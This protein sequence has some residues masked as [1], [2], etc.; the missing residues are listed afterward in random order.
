[1]RL[2]LFGGVELSLKTG[3]PVASILRQRKRVAL[4]IHLTVSCPPLFHQREQ[5]LQLLWPGLE[6]D[7]ARH[8]LR[9]M[10]YILRKT[11][12]KRLLLTGGD[13]GVGLAR[14]RV[15]C[16]VLEFEAAYQQ[17][18]F[19][20]AA[21]LYRGE[22]AKGFS[23]PGVAPAFGTWL[24][25]ERMRLQRLAGDSAWRVAED[26]VRR[27][28]GLHARQWLRKAREFAPFDEPLLRR[29]VA[30]LDRFGD[31]SGAVRAYDQFESLLRDRLGVEPSPETRALI[32]TVRSRLSDYGDAVR[33]ADAGYSTP[34]EESDRG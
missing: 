33:A 23:V 29:T 25:T 18:R 26:L 24:A 6:E 30:I 31:R 8:A 4:L 16:D 22:F 32:G 11:L 20:D 34:P 13:Q 27:G 3:R 1:V 28:D 2:L 21:A 9:Q 15:W 12:G 14:D 7:R 17:C 10:L 5:L 19:E